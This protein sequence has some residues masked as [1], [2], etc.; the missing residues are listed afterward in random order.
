M[1]VSYLLEPIKGFTLFVNAK[2]VELSQV[3]TVEVSKDTMCEIVWEVDHI[4]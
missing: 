4:K 1:D 3:G 2:A